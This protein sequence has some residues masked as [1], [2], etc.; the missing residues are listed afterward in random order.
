MLM[1]VENLKVSYGGVQ[2]LQGVSLHIQEGEVLGI[3][4]GNGAGKTTLVNTICGI[5]PATAGKV[6]FQDRKINGLS[7]HA[8]VKLGIVQVPEGRGIFSTLSVLENLRVGAYL[9]KSGE[10]VEKSL[11]QIYQI[12]PVLQERK[13]QSGGSLSG[14][15]QQMLAIGR[16]LMANPR[17]LLMDEPTLGLSPLMRRE[18]MRVIREINQGGTSI[19]L[20]EQ[21]AR[22]TLRIAHRAVVLQNG[23]VVMQGNSEELSK[24]PLLRESYLS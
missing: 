10:A 11:E 5:V 21:N 16:A 2:A 4:G 17:L 3:L 20:V 14:G 15:E 23:Q 6:F 8:I 19:I 1:Q 18:V 24:D 13:N 12:F 7:A 9:Q 22:Q